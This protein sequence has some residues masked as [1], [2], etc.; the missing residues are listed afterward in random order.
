LKIL[1]WI[2]GWVK[3]IQAIKKWPVLSSKVLPTTGSFAI[4]TIGSNPTGPA[5]GVAQ[6]TY[7]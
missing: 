6:I 4:T 1:S 2:A 3:L 5:Q 7:T